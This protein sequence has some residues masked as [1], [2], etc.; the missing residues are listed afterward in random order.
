MVSATGRVVK[1]LQAR[2]RLIERIPTVGPAGTTDG[3]APAGTAPARTASAVAPSQPKPSDSPRVPADPARAT[4]V[5]D[6]GAQVSVQSVLAFA[7]AALLAVA[8][9]VFTFFN[10]DL[11]SFAVRT[12]I[13]AVITVV[14]LGGAWLFA[15]RGLRFSAESVAALGVVFIA[16]DV[17]AFVQLAPASASGWTFAALGT[18]LGSALLFGLGARSG[19]RVWLWAAVVGLALSPGLL[20]SGGGTWSALLGSLGVAVVALG[21]HPVLARLSSGLGSALGFERNTMTT[22]QA[23]AV[24]A[25]LLQLLLLSLTT[26][27]SQILGYAGILA[28]LSVVAALG[29]RNGLPRLW[30]FA[31]G[32]FAVAAVAILP[33][34]VPFGD[35]AWYL[36]LIPVAAG[37]A[38]VGLAALRSSPVARR[39]ALTSGAVTVL[40]LGASPALVTAVTQLSG[41]LF[42]PLRWASYRTGGYPGNASPY[43]ASGD[44]AFVAG[45]ATPSGYGAGLVAQNL[46]LASIAALAALALTAW[47]VALVS[48]ESV[49]AEASVPTAAQTPAPTPA[50]APS[51]P[52]R[53]ALWMGVFTLLTVAGWAGFSLTGQAVVGLVLAG[54]LIAGLLFVPALA[55][56]PATIRSVPVIGA[57]LLLLLAAVTGWLQEST[58]VWVGVAAVLTLAAL[59]HTLPARWRPVYLGLGYAYALVIVAT[60]LTLARVDGIAVLCLTATLGLLCAL[61]ATVTTWLTPRSW[62][63]VLLVSAVP[64]VAG[65]VGVL[66]VRSGWTAL[67]TG[68]AFA[69]AL[70]LMT[71][72]RPGLTLPLRSFAAGLLVPSLAVV[73]VCLGAQ[74]LAT[75]GSPVV[76]PLIALIVAGTFAAT[77]PITQ[78]LERRGLATLEADA[79][80]RWIEA[81]A[82]VTGVLAVL[83][84]LVRTAAGLSTT[85]LVLVILGIGAAVN[86]LQ[87]GRR[88]AWW[89]AGASWTGALWC[90]WAI[91][92][93]EVIEP[94][95]LPPALAMVIVGAILVTRGR[96]GQTLATT[97]LALAVVPSLLVLSTNGS[98]GFGA[99]GFGA[100]AFGP[101]TPWRAYGLLAAALVLVVIGYTIVRATAVSGAASTAT[102][103]AS[104]AQTGQAQT[105]PA[106]TGLIGLRSLIGA[107]AV[108]ATLAAAAGAVQA[109]R[110]GLGLDDLTATAQTGVMVPV[111]LASATATLLAVFAGL[112]AQ[113]DAAPHPNAPSR[114]RYAAATAFLVAGPITA[115]RPDAFSIG[116]LVLLMAMMLGFMLVVSARARSG[117]M[118][119]PPVWFLFVLAWCTAVAGWSERELRV[120]AF[121]IPLGLALLGA[122]VIGMRSGARAV[123]AT[124]GSWPAGFAGSWRL[125]AP[126]IIVTF[127]P[128][129]LA[130]GTDPQTWRAILVMSLALTAILIGSTRR[131]AAP[132]VISLAVLPIE[133]IVVFTVQIGQ[134]INPLLWWITLATIGAV[135]LV[136]AITSERKGAA[137][138]G[139]SA[140]LRDLT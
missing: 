89:A 33:L 93:I 38:L 123:P 34:A 121:S 70:T 21:L 90:I 129:V 60:A 122:G 112:L 110:W 119:L 73:V 50:S 105:G 18:L 80:R 114:W 1:A 28:V 82:A 44:F 140:R 62:Y 5:P 64:F 53:L 104:Q 76:L 81:S 42:A 26:I 41:A 128:S 124:L 131:L 10:P 106:P 65:V 61:A 96:A 95:V 115:I 58:T 130:T 45:S 11:T 7:G 102:T 43:P 25:A 88:S 138:G 111:L 46:G 54:L 56:A 40:A 116:T 51:T 4:A 13:V 35:S 75:S 14:F 134:T 17:W 20:G 57:H 132:F 120:E 59:A 71:S 15:R 83:L 67:S 74:L 24:L 48:R 86:A 133:V 3:T 2:D 113:G 29:S 8:A 49:A 39:S 12:S 52:I 69:L 72:R 108:V 31:A 55:A 19:V 92:G 109:M 77:G 63:A 23:V 101:V 16:L 118:S 139:F 97:G 84:A 36:A 125:L 30:S 87:T 98:A 99:A 79:C 127:L 94:Y 126:G 85:V 9:L 107:T 117:A 32:A 136:I 137:R 6:A 27:T 37:V 100:A 78:A 47:A 66:L 91:R 135:M 22:L 68:V 103:P